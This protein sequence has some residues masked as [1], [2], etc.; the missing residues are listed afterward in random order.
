MTIRSWGAA[1]GPWR[2]L[3][4]G[5]A[6]AGLS[7]A[8]LLDRFVAGPGEGAEVAFAALVE[9]HGPMVLGVC[10]RIVADRHDADDAFQATFLILARDARSVRVGDTLGRWLY[11]VSRRVALRERAVAARRPKPGG[12]APE[13][14]PAPEPVG[15]DAEV[16]GALDEEVARLPRSIR[17]AVALCHFEGLSFAEAA[18]RLGC[19]PGTVGSRLTRGRQL[20]RSRLARRGFGPAAILL[21]ADQARAE[22]PPALG[23]SAA[24][25]ASAGPSGAIPA[26]ILSLAAIPS[27]TA[28][29]LKLKYAA[30]ATL[31]ATTVAAGALALQA[32]AR[33]PDPPPPAPAAVVAPVPGPTPV[34]DYEALV[35]QCR[36]LL[37]AEERI[38]GADKAAMEAFRREHPRQ[39]LTEYAGRFL[40]LGRAQADDPVAFDALLWAAVFGFTTDAADEAAALLARNHSRDPRL[41]AAC[42]EMRRWPIHPAWGTLLR[43]VHADNPDRALRGRAGYALAEYLRTQAE[44]VRLARLPGPGPYQGR[45][46]SDVRMAGFRKLDPD[47]MDAEAEIL[48]DRIAQA[49]ADVPR[50][51]L[52]PASPLEFDARMIYQVVQQSE[53]AG[54]TLG[55]SA[56]AWLAALRTT[57]VGKPAPEIEGQDERGRPLKLSDHRG[58]VVVLSFSGDWCG[59]CVSMYPDERALSKRFEGRPFALLG[60]NSDAARAGLLKAVEAGTIT[61]HCWWEPLGIEVGPIARQW[62]VHAWPTVIAIDH[63]GIIRVRSTGT[64][65]ADGPMMTGIDDA[66]EALVREAEAEAEA[67][68]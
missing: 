6:V 31:A 58:K 14:W 15:P 53:P 42:Q 67:G 7:D 48:Y 4:E 36:A 24:R 25:L 16:R 46:Y 49:Y 5:G 63:R 2:A 55:G 30:A 66:V 12:E 40:E 51:D 65:A 9:R 47:A 32:P 54:K 59:P 57:A 23:R 43:A 29:L 35:R 33:N 41:W 22:V 56:L 60:V 26:A 62:Q 50:V 18:A 20:L 45:F 13:G 61:W 10:R 37:D 27:R 19:A 64:R 39:A 38:R 68:R 8:E 34:G 28:M 1:S 11:G 52:T 3:F 21:L 17:E 44:F